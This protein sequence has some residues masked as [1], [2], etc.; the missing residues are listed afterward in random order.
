[1]NNL[2]LKQAG[3]YKITCKINGKIY[4]GSSVELGKRLYNHKRNLN[5]GVH[6]SRMLQNSWNKYGA[7]AFEFDILLVCPKE[8]TLEYEQVYLDYYKPEFNTQTKA[9]NN[10]LVY[11]QQ[12]KD[13]Q[14]KDNKTLYSYNGE[15]L[16]L[17]QIASK[18][19]MDYNL[20]R[21]RVVQENKSIEE[22]IA[23]GASKI[24]F[25]EFNGESKTISAWA[26]D[27]GVKPPRLYWYIKN[28]LSIEEA[29]KTIQIAEKKISFSELC[30]LNNISHTT[31]KSRVKSGMSVMQA[32]TTKTNKENLNG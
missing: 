15:N 9:K 11:H 14:K 20:L 17:T 23:L 12:S 27:F 4:I 5:K 25:Y 30:R 7:N 2:L 6:H 28:G 22:A 21:R 24:K 29:L 32:V 10:S 19:N 8:L 3:I 16:N 31:A 26:R 1:M 18:E 13:R